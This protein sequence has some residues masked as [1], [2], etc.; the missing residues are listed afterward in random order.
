MKFVEPG[1]FT[2]PGAAARKLAEIANAIE[3]VQDGRICIEL[4][5]GAFLEAGGTADQYRPA[6]AR[7]MKLG[8]LLFHESGIRDIC[9]VHARRCRAVRVSGLAFSAPQIP[10]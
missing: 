3:S 8:W 10:S 7:A 4:V 6:L 1:R 9:E 5:N 2:D